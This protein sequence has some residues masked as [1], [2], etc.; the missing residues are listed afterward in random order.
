MSLEKIIDLDRLSRFKNG[1]AN[2]LSTKQDKPIKI[3]IQQTSSSSDQYTVIGDTKTLRSDLLSMVFNKENAELEVRY[4]SDDPIVVEAK[5]RLSNYTAINA[6]NTIVILF[7]QSIVTPNSSMEI[8]TV[9]ED[10]YAIWGDG[11]AY[12]AAHK[13]VQFATSSDIPTRISA[14]QNDVGYISSTDSVVF[15]TLIPSGTALATTKNFGSIY[16]T[17]GSQ[18]KVFFIA[19]VTSQ[20]DVRVFEVS[21]VDMANSTIDLCASEGSTIYTV[22]LVSSGNTMSG[23]LVSTTIPTKVSDLTNDSGYLT[24]YT[25][26]D[27]TV[28]TWAKAS[29]KPTYTAT[30]VGALPSTTTYAAS[31]QVGGSATYANGLHFAQVDSTSTET[32]F[33]VTIPGI[34]EYY[35]GLTIILKNGVVTS[36]SGFTINVNGLGAKHSYTNLAAA[37][38][39]T[40]L[41]NIN[42]TMMFVYDS[43]RVSGG[44]WICY[45]G[46]DANTNTI[47]YQ[48]R[49][50]S[51]TM[52]MS[53]ITYRYRLFFTSAD[54]KKFV[55]ANTSSS[56]NATATRTV[57]QTPIDPHGRIV[58]YGATASVAAGSRPAATAL[59]SRYV[60][61]LGYSFNRTGAAL[62]LTSYAPVY[63][64]AA[65]Q[66]N[67]SAI[68]D[69]TTPYVQALPTT[70]DGMIYI[71]LGTAASAT[72]VELVDEHPIYCYRN[73]S[74]QHWTG[75][76]SEI[77]ALTAR[78]DAL[79]VLD[80][81]AF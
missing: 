70:A 4:Y 21:H 31:P 66:A 38:A 28:P 39:D 40:T 78:L 75:V 14:L 44:G 27:P 74:I 34:T 51:T 37:T 58:Y 79:D 67:G 16:G 9:F 30:E 24:S 81:E 55:P 1:I 77:D 57:N 61:T 10:V 62:T 5:E 76:Q 23:E 45:R 32:A 73:G 18:Q 33:T 25:E 56:T 48:L 11:T 12:Y 63:I 80:E 72:T 53:E 43:T 71:F 26:T 13:N 7:W 15:E 68:I 50:N 52:P 47:G 3:I 54:G 60:V 41:F 59:W 17:F 35:D 65:P 22:H 69:A 2:L 64:K 42:Y 19:P 29:T 20:Y 49:T 36:A 6:G 46:Y 8:D